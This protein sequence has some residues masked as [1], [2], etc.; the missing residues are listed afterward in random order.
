MKYG[1]RRG[2]GRKQITKS[3][4]NETRNA[5]RWRAAPPLPCRAPRTPRTY[6]PRG[7]DRSVCSVS[8][9]NS[10]VDE[11]VAASQDRSAKTVFICSP[12]GAGETPA[13]RGPRNVAGGTCN[14]R[15][16]EK[17]RERPRRRVGAR[18]SRRCCDASSRA[19]YEECTSDAYR[20]EAMQSGARCARACCLAVHEDLARV[21]VTHSHSHSHRVS[22]GARRSDLGDFS[23]TTS[24]T[25][26]HTP[27]K[28]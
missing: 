12:R 3:I 2:R 23:Q 26:P 11:T 4:Q 1:C 13:R 24:L 14:L 5:A 16:L 15:P 27:Q 28:Q 25:D 7:G 21:R 17:G 6:T 8:V 18:C 22:G 10:Q 19:M 9:E 20:V